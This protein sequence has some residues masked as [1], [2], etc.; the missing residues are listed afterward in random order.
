[1]THEISHRP[2]VTEFAH[3]TVLNQ[4]PPKLVVI[5]RQFWKLQNSF[6]QLSS[7]QSLVLLQLIY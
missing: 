2:S 6:Q 5:Y 3:V 4:I 7:S 1:M